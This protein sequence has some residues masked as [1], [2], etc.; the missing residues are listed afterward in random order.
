MADLETV[1]IIKPTWGHDGVQ[2]DPVDDALFGLQMVLAANVEN[3]DLVARFGLARKLWREGT[4]HHSI[5]EGQCLLEAGH[6]GPHEDRHGNR[7]PSDV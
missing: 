7:W 4:C 2:R 6:E 5:M 3:G 1:C